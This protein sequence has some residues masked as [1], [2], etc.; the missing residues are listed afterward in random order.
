MGV[1]IFLIFLRRG[2]GV[3]TM[4]DTKGN[5]CKVIWF[6]RSF[7]ELLKNM[8]MKMRGGNTIEILRK[9]LWQIV[10]KFAKMTIIPGHLVFFCK[11]PVY[12]QLDLG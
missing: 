4:E 11:Q 2:A 12:K 10:Q 9:A 1:E 8:I 3:D 7:D 5:I 6:S